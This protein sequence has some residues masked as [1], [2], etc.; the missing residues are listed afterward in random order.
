[1]PPL[2]ELSTPPVVTGGG[3]TA[4]ALFAGL[5]YPGE[6]QLNVVVPQVGPGAQPIT[7]TYGGAFSE[8]TSPAAFLA[9]GSP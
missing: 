7:M 5:V 9:V 3:A 2:I 4:N 8:A 1:M 6:W